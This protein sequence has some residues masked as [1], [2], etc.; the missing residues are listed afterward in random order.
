MV[1]IPKYLQERKIV[2]LRERILKRKFAYL[3]YRYTISNVLI[4]SAEKYYKNR[5][6]RRAFFELKKNWFENR[7]EWRLTLRAN[8][9]YKFTSKRNIFNGWK[10]YIERKKQKPFIL[11]KIREYSDYRIKRHYFGYLRY[12]RKFSLQS[13]RLQTVLYKLIIFSFLYVNLTSEA[14]TFHRNLL[15]KLVLYRHSIYFRKRYLK[16][17]FVN[18]EIYKEISLIKKNKNEIVKAFRQLKYNPE[19]LRNIFEK[20][21]KFTRFSIEKYNKIMNVNEYYNS[22]L[23]SKM[24]S[25]LLKYAIR[26]KA[27]RNTNR[28][29]DAF[30]TLKLKK[31][32]LKRWINYQNVRTIKNRKITKAVELYKKKLNIK[33]LKQIKKYCKRQKELKLIVLKIE[34]KI[35]LNLKRKCFQKI[36]KYCAHQCDKKNKLILVENFFNKQLLIK[37]FNLLFERQLFYQHF[38]HKYLEEKRLKSLTMSFN[39]LIKYKNRRLQKRSNYTLAFNFFNQNVLKK[40]LTNWKV[41]ASYRK[42]INQAYTNLSARLN[43]NAKK[44]VLKIFKTNVEMGQRFRTDLE[45]AKKLYKEELLKIGLRV[46]IK[47]AYEK[48]KTQKQSALEEYEKEFVLVGKYFQKWKTRLKQTNKTHSQS[49]VFKWNPLCFE[50]PRIPFPFK[51]S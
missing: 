48:N 14:C 31:K 42:R 33:V 44:T 16:T 34:T 36:T 35:N 28:M 6:K 21:K 19:D 37:Y 45:T 30:Y 13:K 47:A 4:S 24:F 38:I 15:T 49:L 40:C 50:Q 25:N 12:A 51:F 32:M 20:W 22:K 3:F 2:L 27:K 7:V 9:H 43:L 8:L 29:V 1:I 17:C 26:R 41:Y 23:K 39:Q 11:Q 5:I 18:L 10:Y 46:I